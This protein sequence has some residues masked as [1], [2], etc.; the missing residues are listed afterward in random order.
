MFRFYNIES[1]WYPGMFLTM[2]NGKKRAQRWLEE[3]NGIEG[4][5]DW[6]AERIDED[7]I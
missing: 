4:T 1:V 6:E 3:W 5:Q 7:I 2:M